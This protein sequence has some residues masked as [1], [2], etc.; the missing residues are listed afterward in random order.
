M[1]IKFS[2]CFFSLN[3]SCDLKKTFLFYQ[4]GKTPLDWATQRNHVDAMKYLD[5]KY[6]EER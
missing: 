4:D 1:G 6:D 5:A 2:Y 3:P